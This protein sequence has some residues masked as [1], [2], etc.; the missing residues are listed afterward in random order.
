MVD[1]VL[2]KD[3]GDDCPAR[4]QP[5]GADLG[6]SGL[7]ERIDLVVGEVLVLLGGL[8]EQDEQAPDDGPGSVSVTSASSRRSAAW[9]VPPVD[10]SA[11]GG[12]GYRRRGGS[13]GRRCRR[14]RAGRCD[15]PRELGRCRRRGTAAGTRDDRA[16]GH[17]SLLPA[18]PSGRRRRWLP[19]GAWP[20]RIGCRGAGNRRRRTRTL[21]SASEP[22]KSSCLR[23]RTQDNRSG[24]SV[25]WASLGSF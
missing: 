7:E 12:M 18:T 21:V 2:A 4:E 16:Q 22:C 23:R 6:L 9:L 20:N 5:V 25:F 15:Q 8:L 14:R 3:G 10:P 11:A 17:V 24:C 13:R 19:V 1:Q